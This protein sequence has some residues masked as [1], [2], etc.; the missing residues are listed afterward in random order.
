MSGHGQLQ[1]HHGL[2]VRAVEMKHALCEVK[3]AKCGDHTDDSQHCGDAENHAHIPRFGLILIMNIIVGNGENCA[4]IEQRQHHDHDGRH[5]VEVKNQNRQ[6]HEEQHPQRLG[7]AV[8]RVAVHPLEDLAA[9]LDRINDDGQSR[10]NQNNGRRR[11]R[12]IRGAGHRDAAVGFLQCGRVIDS[13]AGHADDVAAL[14]QILNNV[15]LVFREHLREAVG[16]FN[17]V[18]HRAGSIRLEVAQAAGIQNVGSHP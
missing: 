7:D 9:L 16:L 1:I 6:R 13:V 8:D 11:A 4:I 5:R 3:Q 12:R 14:L 18:D 17:G 2:G 10:S 15:I